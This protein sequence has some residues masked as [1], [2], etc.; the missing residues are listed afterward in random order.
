MEDVEEPTPKPRLSAVVAA[1]LDRDRSKVP[2]ADTMVALYEVHARVTEAV[3]AAAAVFEERGSWADD[4]ARTAS[5]WM[6]TQTRLPRRDVTRALRVGRARR[7]LPV[8]VAAWEGGEITEAH[9]DVLASARTPA[10]AGALAR[11]EELLVSKA[12]ELTFSDFQTAVAYWSTFADPDDAEARAERR[13]TGRD[14]YLATSMDVTH[15]GGTLP[16]FMGEI[17]DNEHRR[18]ERLEFERDWA[19][20]TARL[21][22]APLAGELARSSGQR[23]A[24]AFVAMATRSASLGSGDTVVARPLITVLVDYPTLAGP[25]LET[26]AGTVLTPGTVRGLLDDA[27]IERAVY[28]TPKRVEMSAQARLFTGATRRGVEVR[29]RRCVHPMCDVPAERC[30]IDH[31]IPYARGGP[32][33]QEN[34]RVMCGFHNRLREKPPPARYDPGPRPPDDDDVIEVDVDWHPPPGFE[35]PNE[36]RPRWWETDPG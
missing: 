2:D 4:G 3:N 16:A 29:D 28:R 9:V 10:T 20:A 33:T 11:D 26:S 13:F 24:D 19:E 5:A 32:S 27:M 1:V 6:C 8:A 34:G 21:G 17:V 14:V 30:E 25:V 15:V 23:R 36:P 31:L 12:R 35:H 22:R 18:L 7:H